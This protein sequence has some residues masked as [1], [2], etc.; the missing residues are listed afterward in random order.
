MERINKKIQMPLITSDLRSR[1]PGHFSFLDECTDVE[2]FYE[3]EVCFFPELNMF[4]PPSDDNGNI[5]IKYTVDPNANEI[6]KRY[7]PFFFE[8]D[9]IDFINKRVIISLK[10]KYFYNLINLPIVKKM[11][12][13]FDK[14]KNEGEENMEA[15]LAAID[16]NEK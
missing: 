8:C 10:E 16:K 7:L 13:F 4:M 11:Q 3:F 15:I 14:Y 6:D 12:Q 1:W 9:Y 5:I 2:I